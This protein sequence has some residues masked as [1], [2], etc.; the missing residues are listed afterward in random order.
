ML[1]VPIVQVTPSVEYIK[2][3]VPMATN[4][5]SANIMSYKGLEVTCVGLVHVLPFV[6]VV[7]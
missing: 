1:D 5:L 7:A 6:D 2:V 3:F 4:L